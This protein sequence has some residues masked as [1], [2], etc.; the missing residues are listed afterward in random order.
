MNYKMEDVMPIVAELVTKYTS[1]ESTSV[2]YDKARQLMGAV[3]YCIE[4]AEN[5]E[6]TEI[7]VSQ[8]QSAQDMYQRGYELVC[9]KTKTALVLYTHIM[10]NFSSYRNQALYDT[11]VKGFPKFFKY[12]DAKFQPQNQ[13]LTLDYP[14]LR[15]LD[16]LKGIDAI[17]QYLTYIQKEQEFL[18]E[19]TEEYIEEA[20]LDY[21]EDYEELLINIP[22]VVLRYTAKKKLGKQ[23]ISL[24]D[25]A[26]MEQ[27]LVERLYGN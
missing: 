3:I 20:M 22:S 2:S 26:D 4:E 18:R 5:V 25:W 10:E 17:Y 6:T 9:E 27:C 8:S 1:N 23:D 24:K 12:Y 19:F 16:D 14:T 21:H 7:A 13:I 11:V 15:T